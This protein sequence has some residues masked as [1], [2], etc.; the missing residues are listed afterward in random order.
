MKATTQTEGRIGVGL[1]ISGDWLVFRTVVRATVDTSSLSAGPGSV[2][3]SARPLDDPEGAEAML[4][5]WIATP[6]RPPAPAAW[7]R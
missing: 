3:L 2:L 1:D 5:V 4:E 7:P 6:W